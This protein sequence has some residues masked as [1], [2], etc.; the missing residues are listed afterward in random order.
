MFASRISRLILLSAALAAGTAQGK[1]ERDL[2]TA[3]DPRTL[4]EDALSRAADGDFSG[5]VIQ[6]KNLL[7]QEPRDLPARIALGRYQLRTGQP[8][9]AEKELQR[10]LALGADKSQVLPVLGNAL[11]MQR[12]YEELLQTLAEVG[13]GLD[14]RFEILL[15]RARA[16]LELGR[17]PA[18]GEQF[19]AARLAAPTHTEPLVGLA[20]VALAKG[21]GEDAIRHVDSA[22]SIDAKD[23]EA[24][25]QKGEIARAMRDHAQ[26][27]DAWGQTLVLNP[28]HMRARVARAGLLIASGDF[29]SALSDAEYVL[30]RNPDDI[31]AAFLAGQCQLALG[32]EAKAKEYFETAGGRLNAI[33]EDALMKEPSLLRM[34]SFLFYSRG[35]MVRAERYL[36]RYAELN[37]RDLAMQVLLGRVQLMQGD[38]KNAIGTLFPL[39]K[40]D[41]GNLDILLPLGQAYFKDGHYAEAT[42][43]FEDAR[44]LVPDDARLPA[45]IALSRI[46]IGQWDEAMAELTAADSQADG[47]S[48]A[49][50]L[51]VLLNLKL[52]KPDEALQYALKL[53]T[54]A[55]TA[56]AAN[57]VGLAQASRGDRAAAQASFQRALERDP[58]LDAAE[59]NLAKLELAAGE[60][61]SATRRFNAILARNARS[62]QAMQGLADVALMKNEPRVAVDW[63][64]KA[65]A[66]APRNTPARL[67]LVELL[68]AL[69]DKPAA[70]KSAEALASSLPE[71]PEALE[72]L[73]RTQAAAGDRQRAQ[74]S[75]REAVRYAGFNL[76]IL[77]RIARE[78]VDQL[79]FEAARKTLVKAAQANGDTSAAQ[80]ALVRLDIRTRRFESARDRAAQMVEDPRTAS[81]GR[82]LLGETALGEGK[83][84]GAIAHFE[85]ALARDTS[86][87][88]M[89]GLFDAM[90]AAGKPAEAL[91]RLEQWTADHPEDREARRK[92]ALWYVPNGRLADARK[93]L[94]GLVVD[95]PRDPVLLS[96]L[97]RIY[98]LDKDSRAL[99]FAMRAVDARPDWAPGLETLGWILVTQGDIRKGLDYLRQ[100]IAREENPLT[101]MHIA[102]ALKESGRIA[103]A[104]AELKVLLAT[105][106][107]LPWKADVEALSAS[108]DTAAATP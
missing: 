10:A 99:D 29:K 66:I 3:A 59:H 91:A 30:G 78:Q 94:E 105:H 1:T 18:A 31:Q 79:D 15:L 35:D 72:L 53:E 100:S 40:R 107:T 92:L 87:T 33:K 42:A 84:E 50:L 54:Q 62:V 8:Q 103:E 24:W 13:P 48:S 32:E 98:Q 73:G 101:R 90:N 20:Q 34:A 36:A 68:L 52:G 26:A 96:T 70:L 9:A 45:Q 38:V 11:L 95:E 49:S 83:S 86:T 81:L 22:L 43:M 51:L 69:G 61:D 93:M 14:Q 37:P 39:Y 16:L 6:L 56:R 25:Y 2:G 5:A 23:T 102:Q 71:N 46:G 74:R 63:L 67:R 4:Y 88:A 97:A 57:L 85:D 60:V 12:K 75:F 80:A 65:V 44:R 58:R 17:L 27:L 28:N 47:K 21:K 106:P 82:I 55:P 76:P 77:M 41:P 89:L 7:Q 64:G 108:L 19:E 104:R